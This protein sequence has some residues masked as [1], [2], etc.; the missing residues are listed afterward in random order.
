[1]LKINKKTEYALIVLKYMSEKDEGTLVS[2]REICDHFNTPF[3]TTAKVMQTMN[4]KDLLDSV[5]GLKGGYV[6][7][8]PL[9]KVSYMDLAKM[10]EPK[11]DHNFCESSKGACEL[12]KNCN[13]SSP[14]Q[15][16]N[17]KLNSFLKNLSLADL[18]TNNIIEQSKIEIPNLTEKCKSV[19]KLD[20]AR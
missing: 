12:Q 7:K 16:L 11:M 17:D 3:D 4:S 20:D 14:L 2:V 1:M 10:I 8:T 18:F 15:T 9:S 5:K 19:D 6:L 13:I